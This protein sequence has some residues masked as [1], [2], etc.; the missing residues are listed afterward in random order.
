MPRNTRSNEVSHFKMCAMN[1]YIGNTCLL[2]NFF[3][4]DQIMLNQKQY[5]P[6]KFHSMLP[7][8]LR[9]F[10]NQPISVIQCCPK[11]SHSL[12]AYTEFL[13]GEQIYRLIQGL[14]S[15]YPVLSPSSRVLDGEERPED[16]GR[17]PWSRSGRLLLITFSYQICSDNHKGD[18]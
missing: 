1:I 12:K 2:W 15:F 11:V 8:L 9:Q 7:R 16:C 14:V 13:I 4:Q 17:F 10:G 6:I 5:C 3:F 18:W